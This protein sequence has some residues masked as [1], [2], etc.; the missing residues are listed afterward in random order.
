MSSI[1]VLVRRVPDPEANVRALDDG[2]VSWGDMSPVPNPGDMSAIEIALRLK[3]EGRTESVVGVAIGQEV[4]PLAYL[5]LAMGAD[6]AFS[7]ECDT[8]AGVPPR[9]GA[10]LLASLMK[11][12]GASLFFCGHETADADVPL[13]AHFLSQELD[14][15]IVTGV[16]DL[17]IGPDSIQATR[18]LEKGWREML[19][20]SLPAV[21]AVREYVAEARYVGRSAL[22]RARRQSVRAFMAEADTEATG[23][24]CPVAYVRPMPAPI[25]VPDSRL[26]ALDRIEEIVSG[27]VGQAGGIRFT[28]NP[29]EVAIQLADFI[30][31]KLGPIKHD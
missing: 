4:E 25:F 30:E 20:V 23:T 27:G 17:S 6:E 28:G 3:E 12:T 5:A 21:V 13:L 11:E 14:W 2:S 1:C 9:D 15:P 18:A 24:R 7:I 8:Q 26:S 29:N 31:N 10:L 22:A 19:E 16:V